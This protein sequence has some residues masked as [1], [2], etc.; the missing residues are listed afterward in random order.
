MQGRDC[1]HV[2]VHQNYARKQALF[3]VM[4]GTFVYSTRPSLPFLE[5]WMKK[6]HGRGQR[7]I[8]WQQYLTDPS[9]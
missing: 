4:C 2:D 3:R 9:R 7:T 5:R 6:I 8:P 1:L